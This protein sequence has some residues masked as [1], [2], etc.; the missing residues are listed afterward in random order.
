MNTTKLVATTLLA[1]FAALSIP[2]FAQTSAQPMRMT[3]AA[4]KDGVPGAA[5]NSQWAAAN[6]QWV[7]PYGQPVHEKTRAEVYQE[8]VQAEQDGQLQYLN[9]TL[10]A[11]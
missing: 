9:S 10:Y 1:A 5:T 3:P 11:H 2:A 8:L 6:G 4:T 7:A